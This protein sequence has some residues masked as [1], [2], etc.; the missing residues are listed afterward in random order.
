MWSFSLQT[1]AASE[2]GNSFFES[3]TS[4]MQDKELKEELKERK[5]GG[6]CVCMC[7]WVSG[8]V[9]MNGVQV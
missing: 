7:G 2:D 3:V 4:G 6:M 8:W 5:D 9:G 1:E